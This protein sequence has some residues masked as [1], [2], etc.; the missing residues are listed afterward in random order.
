[1]TKTDIL[2]TDE[3]AEMLRISK[4]TLHRKSW[5]EKNQFPF[6]KV[7]KRLLVYKKDAEVWLRGI[8]G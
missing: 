6:K 7:G 4:N 5:R 1:M 2:T 8:N 3:V